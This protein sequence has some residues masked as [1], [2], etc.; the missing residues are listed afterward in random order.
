MGKYLKNLT[1][2]RDTSNDNIA[3]MALQ[4]VDSIDIQDILFKNMESIPSN[5]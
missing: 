3:V 2:V 4:I 1:F 5:Q